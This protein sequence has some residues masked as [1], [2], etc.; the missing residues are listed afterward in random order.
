ML[1]GREPAE[2]RRDAPR[3]E[4]PNPLVESRRE[5]ARPDPVP[6]LAVEELLLQQAEEALGAG[7]VAAPALARHAAGQAGGLAYRDP[8]RS[9]VVA[10]PA[11]P[12]SC[13][14]HQSGWI[15][16]GVIGGMPIRLLLRLYPRFIYGLELSFGAYRLSMSFILGDLCLRDTDIGLAIRVDDITLLKFFFEAQKPVASDAK[17]AM[18]ITN[19]ESSFSVDED[20]HRLV[21][22]AVVVVRY[23]LGKD[24]GSKSSNPDSLFGMTL[25]IVVSAPA[26]G[27]TAVS[28][29]HMAGNDDAVV[30]LDSKMAHALRLE[31]IK[32][33]HSFASAKLAEMSALSP[34]PKVLLPVI[35][36][37]E[38]LLDLEKQEIEAQKTSD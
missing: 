20:F 7:V 28:A 29:R 14:D 16:S 37:D 18:L 36:T 4:S 3:A 15:N 30:R 27:E 35:D 33:G 5:L 34:S 13:T 38:L 22:R 1:V 24:A 31:A 2:H 25:G 32:A 6:V 21:L 11:H 8:P 26:M 23:E 12:Q 17:V 10:A 19:P 9:A